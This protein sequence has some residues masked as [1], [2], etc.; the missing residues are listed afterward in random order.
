MFSVCSAHSCIYSIL[1]FRQRN[2]KK[3]VLDCNPKPLVSLFHRHAVVQHRRA[4]KK[5]H[6]LIVEG[7]EP[8]D[9]LTRQIAYVDQ[10]YLAVGLR[11]KRRN[12]ASERIAEYHKLLIRRSVWIFNGNQR[13]ASAEEHIIAFTFC[14][15]RFR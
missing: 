6:V 11:E 15:F 2:N 5:K 13:F 3:E 9:H 7:H 14:A 4:V 1:D 8:A 10:R 12:A